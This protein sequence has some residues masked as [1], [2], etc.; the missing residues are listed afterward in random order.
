MRTVCNNKCIWQGNLP[1]V[2][3]DIR[4][5]LETLDFLV[6]EFRQSQSEPTAQLRYLLREANKEFRRLIDG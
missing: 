1:R 6:E 4:R 2:S 5:T 3:V